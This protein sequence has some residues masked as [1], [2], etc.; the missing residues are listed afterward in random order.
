MHKS[1]LAEAVLTHLVTDPSGYYVDGT[2][3]RGGHSQLILNQLSP[4]GRLLAVDRDLAAIADGQ[5]RFATDTRFQL[6]HANFS[7]LSG[8]VDQQNWTG[9]VSGIL[10]DLGVSSPQI[11]EAERGFS[12]MRDGPLDMRMDSTQ[13]ETAASWLNRA[14]EEEIRNVL[15]RYGEESAGRRIARHLVAARAQTPWHSTLQLAQAI[16]KLTRGAP[17]RHAATRSFQAIRIHIN[18]ELAELETV[19]PTLMPLLRIGGRIGIISFHSLED[20]MVKQYFQHAMQ[21][22]RP[23]DWPIPGIFEPSLCWVEKKVFASDAECAENP[24]ARS[25]VLR[26]VERLK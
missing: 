1:V 14:S 25:A 24:R 3:G 7:R 8:V 23:R 11:D 22:P 12:F 10:L 4:E 21:D 17:G 6:H 13:T 26:V 19:L 18:R 15:Y 2:Y 9:N 16:A 5:Q 20:R